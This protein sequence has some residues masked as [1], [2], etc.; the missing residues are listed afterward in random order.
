MGRYSKAQ[1]LVFSV[2]GTD[3]WKATKIKTIPQ[4][5]IDTGS[6]EFI[7]VSIVPSGKGA[8]LSS[9]SG[10]CIIEIYTAAGKGITRSMQIADL[11]DGFLHGKSIDTVQFFHS[12]MTI[13]GI[14]KDNPKL[15]RSLY[16]IPFNLS[17]V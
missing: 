11:L 1:S 6:A 16:S 13:R 17:G 3:A 12:T 8:N 10:L 14:D 2:F 15:F 7:R 4:N 9:I 5:F